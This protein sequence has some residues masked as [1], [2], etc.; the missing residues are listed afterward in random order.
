MPQINP[1]IVDFDG[2]PIA[3]AEV[4]T[5]RQSAWSVFST[6]IGQAISFHIPTTTEKN[7]IVDL[8]QTFQQIKISG[9]TVET[10]KQIMADAKALN[11][12]VCR[13]KSTKTVNQTDGT[14]STVPDN[15]LLLYTLPGV[16]DYSGPFMMLRETKSSR[17]VIYSPHDDSDG[18]FAT[19]KV[20]MMN[21]YAIACFSDG[22]NRGKVSGGDLNLYRESDWVHCNSVNDNLGAVAVARFADLYP[23]QVSI[24]FNGIANP[25]KC[26]EKSRNAQ[27]E[28]V[29]KTTII[30]NTKLTAADFTGYSPTFTIDFIVNTNYY[31]KC[32]IPTE[33]YENNYPIV[34]DIIIAMEKN[35]WC[36]P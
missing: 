34:G 35:S 31:T 4:L 9:P 24:L 28:E 13:V 11:L 21:S 23:G 1:V 30:A 8:L 32:E 7:L 29:F 22:H 5:S 3:P 15:V 18:T 20:G 10:T 27:M 17:F 12:Y 14:V 2:M 26:M 36:W 16:N 19:T 25:L 6:A 33:T